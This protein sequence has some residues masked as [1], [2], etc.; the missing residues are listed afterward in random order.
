MIIASDYIIIRKA[1]LSY[2]G[3]RFLGQ[4]TFPEEDWKNISQ[5]AKDLISSMLTVEVDKR[6]DINMFMRSPW[7]ALTQEVPTTPLGKHNCRNE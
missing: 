3:D 7:I 1:F 5:T 4:Y 6:I 2:H